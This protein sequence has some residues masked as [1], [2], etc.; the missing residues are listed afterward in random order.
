M[1]PVLHCHHQYREANLK[2]SR[3]LRRLCFRAGWALRYSPEMS[4]TRRTEE[5]CGDHR[6][7]GASPSTCCEF[8]GTG[9]LERVQLTAVHLCNRIRYEVL[10]RTPKSESCAT[11]KEFQ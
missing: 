4:Q 7:K 3:K 6:R 5:I 11:E 8:S 2:S 1:V 10:A 9:V